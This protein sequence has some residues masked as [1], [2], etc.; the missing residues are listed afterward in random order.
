MLLS[1][2]KAY[3]G[4][5]SLYL[6]FQEV[7]KKLL[8]SLLVKQKC[9]LLIKNDKCEQS[10]QSLACKLSS[11]SSPCKLLMSNFNY[12][13]SWKS[14]IWWYLRLLILYFKSAK[15]ILTKPL[16]VFLFAFFYWAGKWYSNNVFWSSERAW[17]WHCAMLCWVEFSHFLLV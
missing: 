4:K 15:K 1:K 10:K 12:D 14:F 16:L 2:Y 11:C 3:W 5:K 9:M 7:P 8:Q 13:F 17:A 6:M